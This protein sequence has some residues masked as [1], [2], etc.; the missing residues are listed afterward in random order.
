MQKNIIITKSINSFKRQCE[1]KRFEIIKGLVKDGD[2]I[3]DV[4]CG[5]GTYTSIPL[6]DLP[7][8]IT[9]IDSDS[10]TIEYANEKNKQK[11]LTFIVGK[12]ENYKSKEPFDLIICSHI[13]EHVIYKTQFIYNMEQLL[14]NDGILYLAIPNGFGWFEVQNF[15]P[16]MLS[17]TKLG[18]RFI[19][20]LMQGSVKD[21]INR[22]SWHVNFFTEK[23]IKRLLNRCGWKI[24]E[25]Y[26]DEFLG[27]IVLDRILSKFPRLA[28][29]NTDI[30][31]KLPIWLT[32]GWVFVCEKK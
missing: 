32:N 18:E 4:G 30:A 20:R 8:D 15:I 31:D 19:N 7:V 23:R 5:V 1:Q 22:D 13:L 26:S 3:L 6:S 25:Q 12:G 21:T 27:G 29:W 9:A 14:K 2:K 11:N 24:K 28:K 17:K 16:R 10:K